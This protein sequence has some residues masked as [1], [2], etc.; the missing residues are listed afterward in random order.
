M[1]LQKLQ[2]KPGVNRETTNYSS[3]GGWYDCDK[4]RFRSGSPQK[5]GGW[6]KQGT[7]TYQ[8]IC[9]DIAN[10]STLS[11]ENLIGVGTH[12]R[13]FINYG[14][15]FYN[16]TPWR[17]APFTYTLGS[18][19]F[20]TSAGS[21]TVIVTATAHSAQPNDFVIFSGATGP[22]GGVAAA[23]FNRTSGYQ[24]TFIDDNT[25]SIE[26]DEPATST[27]TGG[28]SSVVAS[29][30]LKLAFLCTPRRTA[31]VLLSGTARSRP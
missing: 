31:G 30:S 26:L 9:R 13:Y 22:I 14:S 19:P 10:W 1:P 8:G 3:E 16:I 17:D 11:G 27:A 7:G 5:I 2:F 4:I 15:I 25:Y 12:L 29:M 18:N 28:G 20:A 21:K 23:E 6:I 24:I